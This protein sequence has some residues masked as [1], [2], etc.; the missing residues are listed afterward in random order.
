MATVEVFGS[1]LRLEPKNKV[2]IVMLSGGVDSVYVLAKLLK[3]T[4]D[5]ILAHHIHLVNAEGR[6]KV[7]AD[8]CRKIVAWCRE[9]IRKFEYSES[10]I[11]HRGLARK[12]FDIIAVAFEAGIVGRS[13]F[14][15]FETRADRWIFGLCREEEQDQ[16]RRRHIINACN[17][18][19][20]PF[21][22]PELY[23]LPVI[24]KADQLK[25]MGKELADLCWTCRTPVWLENGGFEECGQCPTCKIM[26]R[27]R[28]ELATDVDR[29]NFERTGLENVFSRPP[30]SVPDI[31]KEPERTIEPQWVGEDASAY[32]SKSQKATLVMLSGGVDSVYILAKLLQETDDLIVAHHIHM[33]NGEGRFSVE[34]KQTRQIVTWFKENFR[35]F[36]YS[37]SAIDHRGL[38]DMGFDIISVGYEAGIVNRSF[39]LRHDRPFDRW[40]TG[41]CAEEEA[42]PGRAAHI[43]AICAASSY[44]LMPPEYFHLPV[45]PKLD[46]IKYLPEELRELC[47]TCRR[48]IWKEDG[49][50][51]ECGICMTCRLMDTVRKGL[52]IAAVKSRTGSKK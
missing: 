27:S 11:D 8:R 5:L 10:A 25:Y 42:F 26:Q 43:T 38:Y 6:Y 28:S 52:D 41:W 2:T 3:E 36:E 32:N 9:N 50:F 31:P 35:D 30:E 16:N 15:K 29:D 14:Q 34:A 33:V 12:G 40:T 23:R 24:S 51:E 22:P 47:W 19:S 45:I 20:F 44:P 7:E 37:E 13:Y 17:A 46:Q 21:P 48:P 49:S 1:K 18:T 4:D 39:E